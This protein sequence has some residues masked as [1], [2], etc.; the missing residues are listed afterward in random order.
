LGRAKPVL[1][2]GSCDIDVFTVCALG[3]QAPGLKKKTYWT[4]GGWLGGEIVDVVKPSKSK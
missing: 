3:L 1:S 2:G 4:N